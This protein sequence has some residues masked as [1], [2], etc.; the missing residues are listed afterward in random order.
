M[1]IRIASHTYNIYNRLS[2]QLGRTQTARVFEQGVELRG[3][4]QRGQ[5]RVRVAQHQQP[6]RHSFLCQAWMPSARVT[7]RS[8]RPDS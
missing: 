7:A 2:A 6:A 4:R 3:R 8:R 5:A 1:S